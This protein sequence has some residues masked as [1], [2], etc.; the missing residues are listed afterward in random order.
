MSDLGWAIFSMA[1]FAFGVYVGVI[2]GVAI[3]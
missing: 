3:P 1:T 2:I